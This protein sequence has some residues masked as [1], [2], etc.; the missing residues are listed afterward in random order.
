M[1]F[2]LT[3]LAQDLFSE[4]CGKAD[5]AL[6]GPNHGA[7]L[8]GTTLI[9][10]TVGAAVEAAKG[11]YPAIAFSGHGKAVPWDEPRP[12]YST[13]YADLAL[14]LTSALTKGEKPYL[15]EKTWLNVNFPTVTAEC[16]QPEDFEFVLS[17]IFPTFF[18]GRDVET[19]GNGGILPTENY[20]QN[21]EGCYVSVSVGNLAKGDTS[22]EKQAVVL[23][24]LGGMLSCLP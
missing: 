22:K 16:S 23:E 24:R 9:S 12:E 13:V 15:P 8:G 18:P 20:V 4:N 3:T 14:M 1:R 7:N 6:A 17:R 5:I 2:G 10:G 21:Q 19:C 11:G